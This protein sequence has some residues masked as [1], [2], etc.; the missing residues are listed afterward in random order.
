MSKDVFDLYEDQEFA[1]SKYLGTAEGSQTV[2][3]I[4]Y[5]NLHHK[6]QNDVWAH[7][8]SPTSSLE[9][10]SVSNSLIGNGP[11]DLS[12]LYA[13]RD[14]LNKIISAPQGP[15]NIQQDTYFL[16]R[17]QDSFPNCSPQEYLSTSSSPSP[18][19]PSWGTTGTLLNVETVHPPYYVSQSDQK[20]MGISDLNNKISAQNV[21][22]LWNSSD[23][24]LLTRSYEQFESPAQSH[25]QAQAASV[26]APHIYEAPS[27]PSEWNASLPQGQDPREVLADQNWLRHT[28]TVL[29]PQHLTSPAPVPFQ[30]YGGTEYFQGALQEGTFRETVEILWQR[31]NDALSTMVRQIEAHNASLLGAQ[32]Q[33]AIYYQQHI[34]EQL[35]EISDLLHTLKGSIEKVKSGDKTAS[36]QAV[37]LEGQDLKSVLASIDEDISR[38]F[39]TPH[40]VSSSKGRSMD[41]L[42]E[43]MS[44]IKEGSLPN[45]DFVLP[46]IENVQKTL[47]R[48]QDRMTAL[49][50]STNVSNASFAPTSQKEKKGSRPQIQILDRTRYHDFF[51]HFFPGLFL[52][53][54][55]PAFSSDGSFTTNRHLTIFVL[56]LVIALSSASLLFD[57]FRASFVSGSLSSQNYL[58]TG[59][60]IPP[61]EQTTSVEPLVA[62]PA[63]ENPFFL[64][65]QTE[66]LLSSPSA[67]A[68][69]EE[70][71]RFTP[72]SEG[73]F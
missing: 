42:K 73:H 70:F 16:A 10:P 61:A 6:K 28:Q 9:V 8:R 5:Q 1:F 47:L 63:S 71:F 59:T 46:V 41:I 22:T 7:N 68:V 13:M 20:P 12:D 69:T 45:A 26:C 33:E 17:Q 58:Q 31:I 39:G 37:F 62:S 64:S 25:P 50:S 18:S 19:I 32:R 48:L 51:S 52:Q 29:S 43:T 14:E 35:F 66:V 53:G 55:G 30:N 24:E 72:S 4:K 15:L 3:N 23:A 27:L 40:Q 11:T 56:G 34:E 67:P 44:A 21:D 38:T 49:E 65:P 54:K 36:Q 57:M 60:A 2:S